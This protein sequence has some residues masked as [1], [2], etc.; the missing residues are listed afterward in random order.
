MKKK[1]T[2]VYL[3]AAITVLFIILHYYPQNIPIYIIKQNPHS[4][5]VLNNKTVHNNTSTAFENANFSNTTVSVDHKIWPTVQNSPATFANPALSLD[6]I[7]HLPNVVI[8]TGPGGMVHHIISAYYD[9]RKLSKRP[10]VIMI[11]YVEKRLEGNLY[12]TFVY[13]DNS[14]KCLG[15]ADHFPFKA[16]EAENALSELY[17]CRMTAKDKIPTHVILTENKNCQTSN[18]TKRIPVW[19]TERIEKPYDIGVCVESPLFTSQGVNHQKVFDR[20][21]EFMAMVKVLGAQIVTAYNWDIKQELIIKILKV[22]PKFID[23]VQW[24][25]ISIKLHYY[26]Q[27]EMMF[28]CLYRN[29]NRVKYLAFIDL[30]EFLFPVSSYS[31]MDMLKILEQ[32]G[33]YAGYMFLNNFMAITPTTSPT[34]QSCP[35]LTPKYFVRLKRH[36]WPEYRKYRRTKLIVKP[37]L[38]SSMWVH[39]I[40]GETISGYNETFLVPNSTGMMFHYRVPLPKSLIFDK[41]VEDRTAL[42]YKDE[43]MQEIKRVCSLIDT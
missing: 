1:T 17:F 7:H 11:G 18:Q 5:S 34:N 41:G 26:A 10:A 22:Y 37:Y 23:M 21:V 20:M 36:N 9:S 2:I 35:Y 43:V 25:K 42:K 14:T 16:R 33:K 6:V 19:N 39:S 40:W 30:D 12:C 29:M 38:L 32:K 24:G 27:N 4:N 31:W 15:T 3:C 8:D 28:D 13:E